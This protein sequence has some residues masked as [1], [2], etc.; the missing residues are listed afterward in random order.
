MPSEE[1]EKRQTYKLHLLAD[2]MSH[3]LFTAAFTYTT[4]HA[5]IGKWARLVSIPYRV[6]YKVR[7][8][9]VSYF[10]LHSQFREQINCVGKVMSH[11]LSGKAV[12]IMV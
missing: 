9:K 11:L 8:L 10:F 7:D 6:S 4:R 5:D 3:S 2:C 1:V 12:S